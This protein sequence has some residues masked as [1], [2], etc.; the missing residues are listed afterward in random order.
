MSWY[1]LCILFTC[2][3]FLWS[4]TSAATIYATGSASWLLTSCCNIL[5]HFRVILVFWT[6]FVDLCLKLKLI[7]FLRWYFILTTHVLCLSLLTVLEVESCHGHG[8]LY[9]PN[10][11]ISSVA[12]TNCRALSSFMSLLS[13]ICE[14]ILVLTRLLFCNLLLLHPCWLLT[15]I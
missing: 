2:T 12:G 8:L 3:S 4:R 11:S 7:F 10:W 9:W 6:K 1:L 14:T 13:L 15:S 5:L